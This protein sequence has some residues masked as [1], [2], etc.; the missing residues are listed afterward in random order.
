MSHRWNEIKRIIRQY[1]TAAIVE[2]NGNILLLPRTTL[3]LLIARLKYHVGPR[4]F[5]LY[6]FSKL[7]RSQWGEYIT[8]QPD[9]K[10]FLMDRNPEAS[11]HL[12]SDKLD[13]YEHCLKNDLPTVPVI[14]VVSRH[15]DY[16]HRSVPRIGS[17]DSWRTVSRSFPTDIFIKPVDGTF[18]ENAF[19]AQTK[20]GEAHFNGRRCS[21]DELFLLLEGRLAN[22]QQGY[23][24]QPRMYTA[25]SLVGVLSAKGLATIRIV[26]QLRS[27]ASKLIVAE[28]KIT[29]GD[30]VTD[31][32]SNARSGNLLAA[33]DLES[34]TLSTPWGSSRKD[35]PVIA[36][37]PRHPDSGKEIGG[38]AL[39]RWGEMVDLVLK[40]QQK[41]SELRTI[42][43]DVA[44]T[45]AGV[46]LVEGNS[47][48]GMA[49]IQ[50][51]HQCGWRS[52][53]LEEL[54]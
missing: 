47:T 50:V 31:N 12:V 15:K 6:Q 51:A 38:F 28:A 8:D 3:D 35:W 43:W 14:A 44:D 1:T 32:F 16:D 13:F 30:N 27:G 20:D 26:T 4:H 24:I 23:V 11:R 53:F 29:V 21:I 46:V 40:A 10:K 41:F 22:G 33:I 52:R 9:I 17:I 34:G 25:N 49:S 42:G 37:V 39:P 45:T 7:D 18:G 2:S 19:A 48:Y 5:S 36:Q 54:N